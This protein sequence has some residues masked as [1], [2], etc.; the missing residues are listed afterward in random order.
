MRSQKKHELMKRRVKSNNKANR[1]TQNFEKRK[2]I[3]FAI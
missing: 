2:G 1:Q 3:D